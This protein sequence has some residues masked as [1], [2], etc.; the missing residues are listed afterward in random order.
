MSTIV[1]IAVWVLILGTVAFF[2]IR[3]RRSGRK[4]PGDFDR[5]RHEAVGE[6]TARSQINGPG[7]AGMI[8][9]GN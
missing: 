3:E 5:T 9:G 4:G 1:W 8:G 2:L 6:S 7:S